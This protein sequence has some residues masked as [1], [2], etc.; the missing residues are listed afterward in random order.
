MKFFLSP[1][2]ALFTGMFLA[3]SAHEGRSENTG[4]A[5]RF[6]EMRQN[7]D[8][9]LVLKK[10][11][12]SIDQLSENYQKYLSR[13]AISAAVDSP[14]LAKAIR[15]EADRLES[16][17][18]DY[19]IDPTNFGRIRL[20]F[21]WTNSGQYKEAAEDFRQILKVSVREGEPPRQPQ[22]DQHFGK[23]AT[24]LGQPFL[25]PLKKFIESI[26]LGETSIK[27]SKARVSIG[28][29][30]MPQKSFYYHSYD[31]NFGSIMPD[32][33]GSDFKRMFV[34][35]DGWDQVVAVQFTSEAPKNSRSYGNS[36]VAI[37]NYVQFRRKGSSTSQVSYSVDQGNGNGARIWTSLVDRSRTKEVNYLILPEPTLEL[38]KYAL[39]FP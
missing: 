2:W 4:A 32:G 28:M 1:H 21:N 18:R 25:C 30:G 6:F 10:D 31:G 24:I 11:Q 33:G 29:P 9:Q 34:V 39:A 35:T 12:A 14:D 37:F 17:R 23:G 20:D 5:K 22:L 36:G 7:F 19:L 27:A 16:V 38:I 15:D 26:P 13:S 3:I 8:S